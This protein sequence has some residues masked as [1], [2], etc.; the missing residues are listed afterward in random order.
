MEFYQSIFG[1]ELT[2]Q[3]YDE[4]PMETPTSMEGKLMH[5]G[6]T[7][8]LITIM[9]SDTEQA[10]AKAAKISLSL[11]GDNEEELTAIFANLSEDGDVQYPL[12]KEFW[13]D[14]F[15]SFVDKFGVEWMVNISTNK[16]KEEE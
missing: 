1:G 8:G 11:N 15:G 7:G 5:A 12:K 6:L 13:G 2:T 3:S 10:S 9:G 16:A 14:T 4:V